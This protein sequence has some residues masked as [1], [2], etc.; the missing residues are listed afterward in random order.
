MQ[1]R[2]FAAGAV[3]TLS[4]D[5]PDFRPF[6]LTAGAILV[7]HDEFLF[8]SSAA[9]R[10]YAEARAQL[11][12]AAG[13]LRDWFGA[14]EPAA[15]NAADAPHPAAPDRHR[16]QRRRS[17][18]P[19]RQRG[20]KPGSGEIDDSEALTEMLQLLEE[21]TAPSINAAAKK[22]VTSGKARTLGSPRSAQRRIARKF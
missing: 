7:A 15:P 11:P 21:G 8:L 12:G 6:E 14:A 2:Q 3:A 19:A 22:L 1:N 5:P 18:R 10:R 16:N 9:C 20:R 4:G 17:L 13:L